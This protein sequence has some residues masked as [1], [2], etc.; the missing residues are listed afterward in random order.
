MTFTNSELQ[1]HVENVIYIRSMDHLAMLDKTK[2]QNTECQF[3][4][5]E[6]IEFF[7]FSKIEEI[8][9][10]GGAVIILSVTEPA[11]SIRNEML[12][13]NYSIGKLSELSNVS[14]EVVRNLMSYKKTRF[15][16]VIK[17]CKVLGLDYRTIGT[18]KET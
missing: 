3:T 8:I 4:Y 7:G 15:S 2:N 9:D 14:E 10:K 13:K 5:A 12:T 16:D 18:I 6:V 17:I 11:N 1:K